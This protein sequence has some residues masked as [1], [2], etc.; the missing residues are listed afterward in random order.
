[1]GKLTTHV[2]DTMHGCPAAGMAVRLFRI[3]GTQAL[4]LQQLQLNHD[5]R[6]D[7]P[8]LEGGFYPGRPEDTA[9]GFPPVKVDR[10]VKD[11]DKVT[12]GGVTLT[13]N[14]TPGHSPGCTS[15]SWTVADGATTR[16]VAATFTSWNGR[17]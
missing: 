6:A 9:R 1:M 8:L 4:Q 11:G 16:S 15:W 2:L 5:G 14:A 13:A 12:L 7:K 10:A 17:S 3:D